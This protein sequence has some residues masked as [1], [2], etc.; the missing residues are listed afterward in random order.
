MAQVKYVNQAGQY[1]DD[2]SRDQLISYMMNPLK[3]P[4][5]Y[6]GGC[7]IDM[8]APAEHMRQIAQSFQKD[9]GVRIYHYVLTFI[10]NDPIFPGIADLAA[11]DICSRIGRRYPVVYAVHENT[12]QLHI[13]IAFNA[14]SHVDGYKYKANNE[15][16]KWIVQICRNVL[17][18]YGVCQVYMV[19]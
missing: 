14:V 11:Q 10:R 2:S 12:R 7:S 19:K 16:K 3:T 13:H 6:I 4:S 9:N 17:A 5:H 18:T 8:S 15:E 1:Q